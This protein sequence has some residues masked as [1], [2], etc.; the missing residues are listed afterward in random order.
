VALGDEL[1][2]PFY[3]KKQQELIT[4]RE[5]WRELVRKYQQGRFMRL[6]RWMHRMRQRVQGKR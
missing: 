2:N 3:I 5:H 1:G 6:M 4:E